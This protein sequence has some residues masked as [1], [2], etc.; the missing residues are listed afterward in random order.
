MGSD[1]RSRADRLDRRE[2]LAV[3]PSDPR[4][5]YAGSGEGLHPPDLFGRGDIGVY[6]SVDGGATWTHLGLR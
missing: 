2:A 4:V 5:V 6:K 3:A 1:L